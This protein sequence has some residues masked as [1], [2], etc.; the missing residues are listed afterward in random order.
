MC[1]TFATAAGL[2]YEPEGGEWTAETGQMLEACQRTGHEV[3]ARVIGFS[4][5]SFTVDEL[6]YMA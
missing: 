5:F 2:G 6:V 1:F 3:A 4:R